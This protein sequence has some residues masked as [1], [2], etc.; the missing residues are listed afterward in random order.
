MYLKEAYKFFVEQYRIDKK[1]L[2]AFEMLSQDQLSHLKV[3]Y[4]D[5]TKTPEEFD[6]LILIPGYLPFY[7]TEEG[8]KMLQRQPKYYEVKRQHSADVTKCIRVC[9]LLV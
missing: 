5:M 1:L 2:K 9:F 6:D 7:N 8:L 3:T 4:L